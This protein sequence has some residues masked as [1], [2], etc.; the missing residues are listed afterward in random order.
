MNTG[1]NHWNEFHRA[2]SKLAPPLRPHPQVIDAV[3]AQVRGVPGRALLLGVTPELADLRPQLVAVDHNYAMVANIWP[4]DTATRWAVVGNWLTPSFRPGF[5]GVCVGDASLN[6]L[7]YP[8][9]WRTFCDR[10]NELLAP[11]GKFACRITTAP[12]PGETLGSVRDAALSGAIGNFHAF[13]MRLSMAIASER[14]EPRVPVTAILESFNR[15][16]AD[17]DALAQR[18]GWTREEIDTIDIYKGSSIATCRPT[19]REVL[20]VVTPVFPGARFVAAGTYELADRCPLLIV[21]KL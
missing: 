17:R 20:S 18:A 5:F 6:N 4:G 8:D 16:F 19:Q 9:Q 11:G 10:L 2:W 3:H 1:K 21:E 12:E 7:H 14:C 15:M 13:K